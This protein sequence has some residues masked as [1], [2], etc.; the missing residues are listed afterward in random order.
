MILT[1]NRFVA[2]GGATGASSFAEFPTPDSKSTTL[3]RLD[4]FAGVTEIVGVDDT[5][6][7]AGI[8]AAASSFGG[9][10]GALEP[11]P[12][13]NCIKRSCPV[14]QT[15][16]PYFLLPTLFRFFLSSSFIL[17]L[18]LTSAEEGK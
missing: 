13:K 18:K 4:G 11:V 7:L 3:K 16:S 10:V 6:S 14:V 15:Y 12:L 9:G 5:T 17:T 2:G 8:G 1:V